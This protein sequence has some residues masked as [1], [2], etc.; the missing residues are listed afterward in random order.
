VSE[1]QEILTEQML[2]H[3][4]GGLTQIGWARAP[5]WTYNRTAIRGAFTRIVEFDRYFLFSDMA[6]LVFEIANMGRMI[7][8]SVQISNMVQGATFYDAYRINTPIGMADL[9]PSCNFGAIKIKQKNCI[10]D[11]SVM[12]QG[13]RLIKVDLPTYYGGTGLRGVVV[14]TPSA[15]KECIAT[16]HPWRRDKRAFRYN[17]RNPTYKAE[18]VMQFGND[19]LV[20]SKDNGWGALDWN[21]GYYPHGEVHYLAVASGVS[22]GRQV[23]CCIGYGMEANSSGTENAFFL[24]GRLYKLG[25]VT[26]RISPRDWLSPWYFS[27]DDKRLSM[28]FQPVLEHRNKHSLLFQSVKERRVFGYMSGTYI[29]ESGSTY[30]FHNVPSYAEQQKLKL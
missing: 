3:E 22:G 13:S 25:Q 28:E 8:A 12:G 2:L 17:L 29:E 9:P 21:R 11:F 18:G 20:F 4:K 16:V 15:S 6:V 24:E 27:S 5:L 7:Y 1:Q 23:G 26:F 19:E 10:I 30:T 14:L